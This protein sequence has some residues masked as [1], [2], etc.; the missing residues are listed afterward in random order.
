[1]GAELWFP[2]LNFTTGLLLLKPSSLIDLNL[3]SHSIGFQLR[4]HSD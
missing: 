1:M 3:I 4:Q 2:T